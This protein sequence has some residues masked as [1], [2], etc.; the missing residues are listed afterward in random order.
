ML[1]KTWHSWVNQHRESKKLE[2]HK[3]DK[4][5]D[6][7]FV[8]A[9]KAVGI[10]SAVFV[11]QVTKYKAQ[12]G[13]TGF[14]AMLKDCGLHRESSN[15]EAKGKVVTTL[16]RCFGKRNKERK[17]VD[18]AKT[19]SLMAINLRRRIKELSPNTKIK[20]SMLRSWLLQEVSICI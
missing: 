8:R 1:K 15:S 19:A 20:T 6:Y 4:S 9:V 17:K 13:H 16:Q 5:Y 7:S 11:N 3:Q 12:F 2:P 18:V 14:I 10:S